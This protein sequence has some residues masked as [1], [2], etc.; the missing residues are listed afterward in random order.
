MHI[1]IAL[2]KIINEIIGKSENIDANHFEQIT[3]KLCGLC[4]YFTR[5]LMMAVEGTS[6][7]ISKSAFI[8]YWN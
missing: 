2:Q 3:T 1:F 6:N 5:I 8:K 4:K 7:K